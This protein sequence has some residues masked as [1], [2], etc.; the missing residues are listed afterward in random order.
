MT[1]P[2]EMLRKLAP[3]WDSYGAPA[4]DERCIEK[5]FAIWR[6]LSGDWQVV[7][8]T[9]GGVQLEQHR[10]GF[11]IEITVSRARPST[12]I[13]K[14]CSQ[15][16]ELSAGHRCPGLQPKAAHETSAAQPWRCSICNTM[17]PDDATHCRQCEYSRT[18]MRDGK[19][20]PRT[21]RE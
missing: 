20:V 16:F 7:P 12:A 11:D 2:H 13:C 1:F 19:R 4:I 14:S 6:Q 9:D 17:N 3:N 10:D 8:C 5:A 15:E 18:V 21:G